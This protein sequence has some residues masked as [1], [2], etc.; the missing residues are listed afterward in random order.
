MW[1]LSAPI[2]KQWLLASGKHYHFRFFSLFISALMSAK[3]DVRK[4][5][6]GLG[7]HVTSPVKER[8]RTQ[9]GRRVIPAGNADRKRQ[10]E[11]R[12]CA[13]QGNLAPSSRDRTPEP[14]INIALVESHFPEADLPDPLPFTPSAPPSPSKKRRTQPDATAYTLYDNWNEL[15]PTLVDPFLQYI[16]RSHHSKSNYPGPDS[17]LIGTCKASCSAQKLSVTC[18]Y[19]NCNKLFPP[20]LS[21]MSYNFLP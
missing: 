15:L 21:Q 7:K 4:Q 2:I 20:S 13:L 16:N 18:L 12:L 9:G 10:L 19:F 8:Y 3:R 17:K 14:S 1:G 6:R 5:S 11:E